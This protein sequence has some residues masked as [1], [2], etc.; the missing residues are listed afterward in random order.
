MKHE[1]KLPSS[2][3]V[4]KYIP[5][6]RFYERS[7]LNKKIRDEFQNKVKRVTWKYKLSEE[8]IGIDKNEEVEEIQIFEIELKEKNI[9]SKVLNLINRLIPYPI[10]F[11]FVFDDSFAYG[12]S[13]ID[14]KQT[15]Y[16]SDWDIEIDFKFN[17]LDLKKVY[18]NI[19][20][21]FITKI[22]KKDIEFDRL[23]EIDKNIK[24]VEHEIEVLKSK[25]KNENQF[26]RKVELNRLL[27]NKEDE[28]RE[29]QEKS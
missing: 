22:E 1:L 7:V 4:G 19:V 14:D 21:E 10:L 25:I 12:V 3:F 2:A 5:K 29:L 27:H 9:P 11:V 26:N 18:E 17:G 28:Y 23:I 20:S 15:Y 6:E 8:T 13:L 16:F 24:S